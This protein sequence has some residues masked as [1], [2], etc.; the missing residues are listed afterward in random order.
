MERQVPDVFD[1]FALG[2]LLGRSL[3]RSLRR[4]LG[5]LFWW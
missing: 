2:R 1:V 4:Q 3:G 5:M